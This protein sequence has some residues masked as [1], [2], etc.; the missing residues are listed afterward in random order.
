M[1]NPIIPWP[2]GKRRLLKHLYPHFPRHECYVEAFA[3]GAAA[4]LLRPHPAPVEVLNDVNGELV[5]LYRCVRHH[6]DEFVRMFRWS[7]V[8]RQMWEWAKLERPET[9]T[10]IQRAAR[11]YY[12]QKLAFGGKVHG[13]NFGYVASGSGPRLNLVRIEEELSAVHIRLA[14]VIVE[15]GPW[16]EVVDRYDRPDTFFYFDPP[17]WKTEGYGVDFPWNEYETL[18]STMRSMQGKAVLSIND[19]PD[20]RALFAGMNIIPLQLR[21]TIARD[22]G[23]AAAGELII[24][25]WA[26]DQAQLL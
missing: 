10:D 19:H 15:H 18:A 26:D 20:V 21:Y 23:E 12:L 2:G 16:I 11:F 6:L 4:L 7:L 1:P 24:K 25:S 8:S 22:R 13:Q 17:Y 3:G 14:G 9:L 5:N